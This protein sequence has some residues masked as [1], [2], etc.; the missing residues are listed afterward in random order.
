MR[1]SQKDKENRN[2]Q[3]QR[4]NCILL[5]EPLIDRQVGLKARNEAKCQSA[6]EWTAGARGCSEPAVDKHFS[7]PIQSISE[8][9]GQ[10]C[11]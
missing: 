10:F 7:L 11:R 1:H 9:A 8:K 4:E 2:P 3:L 6:A 5:S